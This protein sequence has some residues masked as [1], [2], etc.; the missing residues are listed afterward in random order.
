ME[1]NNVRELLNN[2]AFEALRCCSTFPL[3]GELNEIYNLARPAS[4]IHYQDDPVQTTTRGMGA[5]NML[6]RTT[7]LHARV[8][9][10]KARSDPARPQ[11]EHYRGS[12]NVNG[13][14]QANVAFARTGNALR[15][16]ESGATE[17]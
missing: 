7:R 3:Y 15:G 12:V 13:W 17:P 4:P 1:I 14:R 6:G 2:R 5:I 10:A 11:P 9:Q 16:A 8:L